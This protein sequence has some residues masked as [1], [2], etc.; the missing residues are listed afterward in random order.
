MGA[1]PAAATPLLRR[2]E[3]ERDLKVNAFVAPHKAADLRKLRQ[4]DYR[5]EDKA[6]ASPQGNHDRDLLASQ[7]QPASM[8]TGDSLSSHDRD[9]AVECAESTWF[10]A[11]TYFEL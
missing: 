6:L 4:A 1:V 5:K 7:P 8:C 10:V 3:L 2:M 9:G 11:T